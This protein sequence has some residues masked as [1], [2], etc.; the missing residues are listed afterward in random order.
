MSFQRI[1]SCRCLTPTPRPLLRSC[2]AQ[3]HW[4]LG[5]SARACWPNLVIQLCSLDS[6]LASGP[7]F[8]GNP[9]PAVLSLDFAVPEQSPTL[10]GLSL[11]CVADARMADCIGSVISPMAPQQVFSWSVNKCFLQATGTLEPHRLGSR[12]SSAIY[13]SSAGNLSEPQ[14]FII[15]WT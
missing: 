6:V 9:K 13:I 11:L 8:P 7:G 14:C 1:G 15:Q 12:S 2:L 3:A 4:S 10:P 5:S